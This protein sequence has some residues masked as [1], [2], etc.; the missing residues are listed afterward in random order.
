MDNVTVIRMEAGNE[1]DVKT[2]LSM[3]VE[4]VT[5]NFDNLKMY[6]I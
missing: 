4:Q 2:V 1:E 6:C 3:F 5:I